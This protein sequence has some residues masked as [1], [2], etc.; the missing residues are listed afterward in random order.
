MPKLIFAIAFA[1]GLASP[2]TRVT[3]PSNNYTPA[4][5]VELGRQ[6]AAQAEQQLP[7][8]RD[9][10]VSSYVEAIGNRLVRAI[11]SRD[12]PFAI[13]YGVGDNRTRFW[14]LEPGRAIYGFWP[15]D[16]VH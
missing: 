4:Q 11:L 6:A 13:V 5:D 3:P 10:L 7:I 16:G 8:L 15:E 14:D 2:Q 9:D 12:V 1:A